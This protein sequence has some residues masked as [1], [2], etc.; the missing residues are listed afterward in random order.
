MDRSMTLMF[1]PDCGVAWCS[2]NMVL[3]TIDW[4]AKLHRFGSSYIR[5]CVTGATTNQLINVNRSQQ[6]R[7]RRNRDAYNV[8]ISNSLTRKLWPRTSCHLC[9]G[10]LAVN[11]FGQS[12]N[13]SKNVVL[14]LPTL[15]SINTVYGSDMLSSFT[16][17][18]TNGFTSDTSDKDERSA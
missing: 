4:N 14:P 17:M 16:A 18:V 12:A 7:G 3:W 5:P 15:P 11:T 6:C 2:S 9:T 13:C 8:E 10:S 1:C